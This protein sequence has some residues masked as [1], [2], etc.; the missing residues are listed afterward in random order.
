MCVKHCITELKKQVL[1]RLLRPQTPGWTESVSP[2]S[3][4]PL[5]EKV[6]LLVLAV[7]GAGLLSFPSN[8]GWGGGSGIGELEPLVRAAELNR[9]SSIDR[10][11]TERGNME[12]KLH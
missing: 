2:T 4:G 6:Y 8:R 12:Q 5:V 10:Q 9:E 1:P 7:L 11:Y 3:P